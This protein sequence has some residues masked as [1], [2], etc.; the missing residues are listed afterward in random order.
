M[1][2][3]AIRFLVLIVAA[4][5]LLA[6]L[7]AGGGGR[8][9]VDN[10]PEKAVG[11]DSKI[12]VAYFSW[13]GHGQQMARWIAEERGGELF[14]IVPAKAY[15]EDFNSCADRAKKELDE[16][17]RP[18]LSEHIDAETMAQYDV[19]Y[20]GFPIWWY[21][22]PMPVWTFLEEYDLSGKTIIPFFSHNGSMGGANS[23]NRIS[24]LT[25]GA[26]VLTDEALS[27]SGNSVEKSESEVKSWAKGFEN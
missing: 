25:K 9:A 11:G 5:T 15:G 14:R 22:L 24:E 26:T 2:M 4:L 1:K 6:S 23:L 19:I 13:S 20:L 18:A 12:L 8:S 3:K 21:D 16:G 27:I 7:P 17:T 10:D